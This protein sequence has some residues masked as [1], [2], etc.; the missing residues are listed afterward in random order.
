LLLLPIEHEFIIFNQVG[1]LGV[2]VIAV[3]EKV[4]SLVPKHL[5][6]TPKENLYFFFLFNNNSS[7]SKLQTQA[8]VVFNV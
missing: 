3:L 6:Q 4:I 8:Y 7:H 5:T 1:I 2:C